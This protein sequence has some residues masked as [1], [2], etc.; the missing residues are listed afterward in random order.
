MRIEYGKAFYLPSSPRLP[1]RVE[2]NEPLCTSRGCEVGG[3]SFCSGHQAPNTQDQAS[4]SQRKQSRFLVSGSLK[5]L[6]TSQCIFILL[7]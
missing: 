7:P 4:V 1:W 2:S 6:I 3:S 5:Y